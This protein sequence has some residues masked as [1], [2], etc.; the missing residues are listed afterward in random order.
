MYKDTVEAKCRWPEKNERELP[1]PVLLVKGPPGAQGP[2]GRGF[3]ICGIYA[4]L[5]ALEA[6]VTDAQ[7][8]DAY[9]VGGG[10]P[11]AVYIWDETWGGQW[12]YFGVIASASGGGAASWNGIYPGEGGNIEA[13][14]ENL[15]VSAEDARTTAQAIAQ[16][17]NMITA[18]PADT[19][20]EMTV[21]DRAALHAQGVRMV[22]AIS[23]QTAVL[24]HLSETGNAVQAY[25]RTA[26]DM[27]VSSSNRKS[28]AEALGEKFDAVNVAN[29]LT[30]DSSIKALSAGMGKKLDESKAAVYGFE[31]TITADGWTGEGPYTQDISVETVVEDETSCHLVFGFTPGSKDAFGDCG[32]QAIAQKDGAVTL[33]ADSLPAEAFSASL[34]VI[35]QGVSA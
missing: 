9:G 11:Y 4:T 34:L 13:T 6:S 33:Q 14:A 20:D 28:V 18:L 30:T 16:S 23:G 17:G 7:Q 24:Y 2:T 10:V 1:L 22:A 8:G 29:D 25:P 5:E 19:F 31:I 3:K 35:R 12:V 32:L 15:P 26:A 21:A 27:P